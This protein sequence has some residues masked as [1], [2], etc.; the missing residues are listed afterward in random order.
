MVNICARRCGLNYLS[1][2]SLVIINRW[3]MRPITQLTSIFRAAVWGNC[4]GVSLSRAAEE[5]TGAAGYP[6]ALCQGAIYLHN[7]G[8]QRSQQAVMV[9]EGLPMEAGSWRQHGGSTAA[10]PSHPG[11]AALDQTTG[12]VPCIMDGGMSGLALHLWKTLYTKM[13]SASLGVFTHLMET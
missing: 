13:A 10:G 1:Y 9:A 5:P 11:A 12:T 7:G 3:C 8:N 2:R 4:A 6:S